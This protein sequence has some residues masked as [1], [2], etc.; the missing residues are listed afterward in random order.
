M[1]K[2][3]AH[4]FDVD[5]TLANVDSI[6][7]YVYKGKSKDPE[8]FKKDFYSFHSES[9]SVPPHEEVVDMA[10]EAIEKDIDILV[11]TARSERWRAHTAYWLKAVANVPH[12]ALFMRQ[13]QDHRSDYEIKKDILEHITQFWDVLHA[14]DDNPNIIRLWEENGIPTTKIG[15]WDGNE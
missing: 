11:V 10:W 1:K 6:V 13:S 9:L 12:E 5:G 2:R 3:K 8:N 7:H 4:I 15:T 14:V